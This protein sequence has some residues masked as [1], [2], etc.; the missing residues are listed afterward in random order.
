[1]AHSDRKNVMSKKDIA[2]MSK[3]ATNR[4][5]AEQ[6]SITSERRALWDALH[7]F[8]RQNGGAISSVKYASPIRLEVPTD[9]PLP[10]RLRALGYDPIFLRA[11]DA[12]RS[13]AG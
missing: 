1:M 5:R 13:S 12:H 4:P 10:E 2:A 6:P 3:W 7:E 11:S 9:S 8:V